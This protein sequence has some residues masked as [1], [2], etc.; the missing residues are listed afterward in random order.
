MPKLMGYVDAAKAEQKRLIEERES[1][2]EAWRAERERERQER[3]AGLKAAQDAMIERLMNPP[4]L[5]GG[6]R[7]AAIL[8]G[9]RTYEGPFNKRGLPKLRPLQRHVEEEGVQ[10]LSNDEKKE[11]WPLRLEQN[12]EQL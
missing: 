1:E 3:V 4:V 7:T 9:M 5:T 12:G 10:N 11:L 2:F 6:E 8:E